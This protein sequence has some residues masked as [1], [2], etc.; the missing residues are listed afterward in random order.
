MSPDES[1]Q[2][3]D[4]FIDEI[5]QQLEKGEKVNILGLGTFE[6]VDR[7]ETKRRN[8]R[9]GEL[10]TVPPKRSVRF[11]VSGLLK[12]RINVED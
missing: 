4:S 5:V 7:R 1:R 2:V 12:R 8:P 10:L 9:N 3:I 6:P 11:R